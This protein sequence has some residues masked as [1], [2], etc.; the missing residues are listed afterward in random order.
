MDKNY[1]FYIITL[2]ESPE[3]MENA[4]KLEDKLKL[5]G[6]NVEIFKAYYYKSVDL[7]NILYS[8]G[9]EY[10]SKDL[11]LSLT[12]IGCFLSHRDIWKKIAKEK[13]NDIHI[14]VEDDMSFEGEL[15]DFSK[16][17]DYDAVILWRHPSQMNTP[18]TYV[19]EGLL[20]FYNQWGTCSYALTP[21]FSKELV[22]NIKKID[23]SLDLLLY[24]DF[25]PNKRV[26]VVEKGPFKNLG[27]IGNSDAEYNFKSWI[28]G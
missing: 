3:R 27:Y 4:K 13:S 22:D 12:Q 14:I 17:P 18:I 19:K 10:A 8:E 25:F 15:Y 23:I 26:F 21:Q 2:F 9:L 24:S 5:K 7:L 20:N 6:Y 1:N 28:Y 11:K 16:I